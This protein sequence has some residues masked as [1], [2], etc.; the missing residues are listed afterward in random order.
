ME[1]LVGSF[2]GRVRV[3]PA[4]IEALTGQVSPHADAALRRRP[5]RPGRIGASNGRALVVPLSEG[6][7]SQSAPAESSPRFGG[8]VGKDSNCH[9]HASAGGPNEAQKRKGQAT[10]HVHRRPFATDAQACPHS[11]RESHDF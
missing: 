3:S 1:F 5:L 2:A 10:S 9:R 7:S 4:Q 11:K 6:R 8:C